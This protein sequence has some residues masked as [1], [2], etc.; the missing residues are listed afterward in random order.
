MEIE[1]YP[2]E[3]LSVSV[4]DDGIGMMESEWSNIGEHHYG[5]I[6]MKERALMIGVDLNVSSVIGEGTKVIIEMQL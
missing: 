4:K 2:R 1:Q 6:G 3:V 5:L